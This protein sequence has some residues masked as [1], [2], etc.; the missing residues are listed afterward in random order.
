MRF[1]K[2]A[3]LLAGYISQAAALPS[4]GIDPRGCKVGG[5]FEVPAQEPHQLEDLQVVTYDGPTYTMT[6]ED[7][8]ARENATAHNVPWDA[9]ADMPRITVES[10]Q[11]LDFRNGNESISKR[12]G[13]RFIA[14]F[15]GYSCVPGTYIAGVK[16]FG[17]GTGCI[18]ISTEALS[19][20]VQQTRH[21]N[22]Y[23]SMDIW[24]GGGCHG[25]RLDH[26]GV[27]VTSSCSNVRNCHGFLSFIGY[28]D[29]RHH[30]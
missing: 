7:W 6:A 5:T 20:V 4:D 14:A 12:D 1:S 9:P 17:C 25:D 19:A 29:C 28:Y 11:L 18:T 16:N 3:L 27:E 23:P 22:P 2:L 13:D 10:G 15:G 30:N 26:F 21:R 8:A 24:T